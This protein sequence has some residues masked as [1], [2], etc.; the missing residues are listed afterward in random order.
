[1]CNSSHSL[2]LKALSASVKVLSNAAHFSLTEKHG[3]CKYN[4]KE[5]VDN[6]LMKNMQSTGIQFHGAD[7]VALTS[8]CCVVIMVNIDKIFAS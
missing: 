3:L 4:S 8:F 5:S 7:I 1:M 2:W 6:C